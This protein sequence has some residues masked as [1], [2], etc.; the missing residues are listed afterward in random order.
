MRSSSSPPV[1]GISPILAQPCRHQPSG[2]MKRLSQASAMSN[3]MPT[4]GPSTAA[5][6]GTGSSISVLISP[7]YALYTRARR[8][9]GGMSALATMPPDVAAGAERAVPGQ[10]DAPDV[11]LPGGR[12]QGSRDLIRLVGPQRVPLLRPVE[13]DQRGRARQFRHDPHVASLSSIP[14]ARLRRAGRL[15]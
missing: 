8:S 14:L 7:W 13:H 15:L 2:P 5:T 4:A 10:H 3:P 9:S 11:W 1:P 12:P 6:V